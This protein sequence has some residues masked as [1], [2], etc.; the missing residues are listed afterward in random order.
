MACP[1]V[2]NIEGN[3]SLG[4]ALVCVDVDKSS[5]VVGL[6]CILNTD[7]TSFGV[8]VMSDA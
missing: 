1:F 3:E 5:I 4:W 8:N 7:V 6:H 2:L